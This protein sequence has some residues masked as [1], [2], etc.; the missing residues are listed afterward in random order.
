VKWYRKAAEQRCEHAIRAMA[1][2]YQ[3]GIGVEKDDS[4]AMR[5]HLHL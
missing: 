4:E 5:W 1:R 2:C 3:E